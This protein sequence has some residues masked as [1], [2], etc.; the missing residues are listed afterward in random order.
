M[1]HKPVVALTEVQGDMEH[2]QAH[3]A[4]WRTD[5]AAHALEKYDTIVGRIEA[6]PDAFPLKYGPVQRALLDRSF[7]IA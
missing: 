6:N 7:Y 3:Y 1:S 5:G 4:S 2:A